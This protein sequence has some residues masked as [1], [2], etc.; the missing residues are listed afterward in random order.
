MIGEIKMR[1]KEINNQDK[2]QDKHL[3]NREDNGIGTITKIIIT[4][5]VRGSRGITKMMGI[6][7][8]DLISSMATISE[9]TG[10]AEDGGD[11]S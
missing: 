3:N 2:D 9:M 8:T 10:T 11:H 1:I 7:I 4:T 6:K 5:K